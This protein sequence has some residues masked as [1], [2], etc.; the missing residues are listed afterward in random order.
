MLKITAAAVALCLAAAARA[1]VVP[2]NFDLS[3]KPKDDFCS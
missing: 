2:E 1:D 3:V